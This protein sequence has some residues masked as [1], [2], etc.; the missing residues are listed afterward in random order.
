[1]FLITALL[2]PTS[3]IPTNFSIPMGRAYT[4]TFLAILNSRPKLRRELHEYLSSD[5]SVNTVTDCGQQNAPR[6]NS[7]NG[8]SRETNVLTAIVH[9]PSS[10]TVFTD[11]EILQT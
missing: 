2:W 4:N 5:S 9:S 7:T 3:M 6:Q 1:M 8:Y 11:I 10:S